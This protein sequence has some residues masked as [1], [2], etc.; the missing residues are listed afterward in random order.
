MATELIGSFII[1]QLKKHGVLFL[2][3]L[4]AVYFI[5]DKWTETQVELK[6]EQLRY[7]KRVDAE[8]QYLKDDRTEMIKVIENNTK[9][10]ERVARD[11]EK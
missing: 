3:L 8:L 11:L 6:S 1:E 2:M 5:N 7:E 9:V 10:M 4:A